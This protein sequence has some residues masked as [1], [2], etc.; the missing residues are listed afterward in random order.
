[1]GN[2]TKVILDQENVILQRTRG[3]MVATRNLS[4]IQIL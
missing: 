1:M 3:R 2:K 4:G